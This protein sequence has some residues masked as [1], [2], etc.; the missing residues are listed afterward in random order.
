MN[1]SI[2]LILSILYL[3][4]FSYYSL[5]NDTKA[6]ARISQNFI[7]CSCVT[8]ELSAL[9]QSFVNKYSPQIAVRTSPFMP[10]NDNPRYCDP[11]RNTATPNTF[12][13]PMPLSLGMQYSP[14]S[15]TRKFYP[16]TTPPPIS[17]A[18]ST[19]SPSSMQ[20]PSPSNLLQR[21]DE[22]PPIITNSLQSR[23]GKTNGDP[24]SQPTTQANFSSQPPD[25]HSHHQ[26]SYTPVLNTANG[27]AYGEPGKEKTSE[28]QMYVAPKTLPIIQTEH[29]VAPYS[30]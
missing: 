4:S 15:Q 2:L 28:R 18:H 25:S 11:A 21:V 17:P 16:P 30:L 19:G 14:H 24:L 22:P 7:L 1:I 3:C 23:N 20:M 29:L 27:V 12:S 6:V 8:N 9:Y 13:F 10:G 5:Q 26:S